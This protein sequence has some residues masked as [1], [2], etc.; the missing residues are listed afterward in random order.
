MAMKGE[1]VVSVSESLKKQASDV[2]KDYGGF[3]KRIVAEESI[4]VGSELCFDICDVLN[5]SYL[6]YS[7]K[8]RR[9]ISEVFAYDFLSLFEHEE[10]LGR[11]LSGNWANKRYAPR[12]LY[13][14]TLVSEHI[15]GGL[16]REF[17]LQCEASLCGL[18]E[19]EGRQA[20]DGFWAKAIVLL[21]NLGKL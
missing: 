1:T 3:W 20:Y 17:S 15:Y 12:C 10:W 6:S 9:F 2:L 19:A 18:S 14:C 7:G 21:K 11:F 5:E 8:E 13:D 16:P 4:E